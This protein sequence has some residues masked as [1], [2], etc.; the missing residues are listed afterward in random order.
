MRFG[1]VRYLLLFLAAAVLLLGCLALWI[2]LPLSGK[3]SKQIAM[4]LLAYRDVA[5]TNGLGALSTDLPSSLMLYNNWN[6]SRDAGP[7]FAETGYSYD[8]L[9]MYFERRFVLKRDFPGGNTWTLTS[10]VRACPP[11][12]RRE[13]WWTQQLLTITNGAALGGQSQAILSDAVI[14]RSLPGN[15]RMTEW[16][17]G[18]GWGEK[19]TIATNGDY[20][21][22]GLFAWSVEQYQEHGRIQIKDGFLIQT[23]TNQVSD[24]V[25]RKLGFTNQVSSSVSKLPYT[26]RR[27]I[28]QADEHKIFLSDPWTGKLLLEKETK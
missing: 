12:I 21:S 25:S 28:I 18:N 3:S 26:I 6:P 17:S 14:S 15:W 27:Q 7:D 22:L 5:V 10:T 2:Y 16:A 11:M 9:G 19:V 23:V 4:A 13:F 1:R 20:S 24:L 8:R